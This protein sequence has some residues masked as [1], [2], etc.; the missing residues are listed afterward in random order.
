VKFVEI[1]RYHRQTILPQ[2]G[3]EGQARLAQARVLL[4]GCGALGGVIAEQL[5]RAGVGF[6]RIVDRDLVELTNLQRQVL[7][8]ESDVRDERPKAVAAAEKLGRINSS[9]VVEP[10][11][12]DLNGKNVEEL[13]GPTGDSEPVNLIMD[14]TDN[15]DTRYL[16]NDMAVKHS[17]PWV[18]GACVGVEGRCLAMAP[19]KTACLRCIFPDPPSPKELP[20][21]DTSGV[22][23]PAAALVASLQVT[24]AMRILAGEMTETSPLIAVDLW[25]S[26][27]RTVSTEDAK[28]AD[29][30]T[31]G[32]GRFEFLDRIT[33]RRSTQ[34]CGRNAVQVST[35]EPGDIDLHALA[36]KLSRSAAVSETQYLVRCDL[37]DPKG[38]RLSVFP[39]GRAIVHG[40]TD[41]KRAMSIYSRFV[42]S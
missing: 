40:T 33:D 8:D 16:L 4:V 21:C 23:G 15:V 32:L 34:L 37:H 1:D 42:G 38:I 2:I 17:I 31:C 9:V 27:F 7:F 19:P 41:P 30:R 13:A 36:L 14:G 35:H 5:V 3:R 28:R 24:A 11:V 25:R 22:L 18:Y 26:R 10:K 20:T 29:C 39:D 6:L 12:L